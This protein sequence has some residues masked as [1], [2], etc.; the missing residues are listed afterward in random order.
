MPNSKNHSFIEPQQERSRKRFEAVLK[1]AEFIYK[2][3]DDYDLTVQVIAKLSGM[4]RPSLYKFFPNNEAI[5]EAISKKHTDNLLFLVKK[6]FESLN[7][8]STTEIVKILI[9]IIAIFLINNSP[10]S[11]LIFTD[12]SKKLIK[13]ELFYLLDSFTN[14]NELK[15][16][17]SLN[18][19][20]SCLEEAFM[21]GDNLSPQQIAETKKACLHYLVN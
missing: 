8:K 2:N 9:D 6:N 3:Q 21:Q 20:I 12:Y 10:I 18:I 5:L 1:T 14:H 7:Y 13:E 19:L 11:K 17:Y 15:I 16:K 4:K